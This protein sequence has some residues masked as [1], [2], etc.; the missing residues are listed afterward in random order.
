MQE[1]SKNVD[2]PWKQIFTSKPVIAMTFCA[3]CCYWSGWTLSLLTP[4]YIN[5]VL[6]FEVDEN[7]ILSSLPYL[8][9]CIL[10][11]LIS[12]ISKYLRK[13]DVISDR[14]MRPVWN[15]IGM[16]G[17]SIPIVILAFM[18]VNATLAITMMTISASLF[19]ACNVG[20]MVNHIDLSPRFS[21]VL[22]SIM[23]SF[24]NIAS[25]LGPFVSTCMIK[26]ETS[27]ADWRNVFLLCGFM[28]FIGNTVFVIFGTT[29]KQKWDIG[30]KH[31]CISL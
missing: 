6:K 9:C 19:V 3:W 7:G 4:S 11:I 27:Q 23:N 17:S 1:Y 16:L 28:F 15:S 2:V 24:G 30:K 20:Y 12:L 31:E 5:G 22:M 29:K 26:D 21:G 8:L 13:N 14:I 10:S 18:P 25:L